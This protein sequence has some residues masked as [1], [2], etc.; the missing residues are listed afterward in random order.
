MRYVKKVEKCPVCKQTARVTRKWVLN[1]YKT[2][3]NYSIYHHGAIDHYSN[4]ISEASRKF[5]KGEIKSMLVDAINSE[6]FKDA[7]FR[8]K[9]MKRILRLKHPNIGSDAIRDNLYRLSDSGMIETV[10]KGRD[11]YFLNAIYKERLSFVNDSL[12]LI[13][14]DVDNNLMFKNHISINT[15]RNDKNWPL[16]YLP[17][18]IFGD[19]DN[20]FKGL[21]F[22]ARDLTN[23][24]I[25][26]TT[27][28]E[29]GAREKRLLLKS[30]KPLFPNESIRI[31]FEYNWDEPKQTFFYTA[32]TEMS[33]FEFTFMGNLPMKI[34]ATQ[35][36]SSLN[37]VKDL[38]SAIVREKSRRWKFVYSLRMKSV[39][40]F[41]IIQFKW[42]GS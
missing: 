1:K 4:Q 39:R 38:S 24:Q 18:R 5:K 3:Y 7:L 22:K 31:K 29:D 33:S 10:K 2:R 37:Q 21:Q 30:S 32:A 14:K 9:E 34:Q 28:L 11:V 16:Y 35:T 40:A 19:S 8:T 15:I 12:R 13:L 6:N 17:Y 42:N 36:I 41:S 25:L 27:V 23:N 26:K 20:E